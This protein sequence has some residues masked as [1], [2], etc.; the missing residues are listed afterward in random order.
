MQNYCKTIGALAAASALVAGTASAEIEYEIH[1]GYTSQY[2]F[3]GQD[4][5]DDLVE[6][7]VDAAYELN[8]LSLSAGA[9]YG[10]FDTAAPGQVDADELDLYAEVAK[11]FGFV[12]AAIGYIYYDNLRALATPG[13][14]DQ[15][16]VYFSVGHEF[17]GFETSLTYFWDVEGDNNGYTEAFFGKKFELS[18]CLVLNTGVTAAY[19]WEEHDFAHVTARVALDW[20]FTETAT[21]SPFVAH[22]WG[23]GNKGGLNYDNE[24]VGGA[25]LSVKF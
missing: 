17:L 23:L 7:G 9:W 11:D 14:P 5:G 4:A 21:L 13:A 10:S 22:S 2:I 1:T 8:G 15:Q 3:R 6:V 12:N 25:L 20:T 18:P 24:L 19:L 16:E